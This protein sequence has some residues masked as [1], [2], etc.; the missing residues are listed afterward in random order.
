VEEAVD[1]VSEEGLVGGGEALG[2][3]LGE[4]RGADCV[5]GQAQGEADGSVTGL[6]PGGDLLEELLGA[7]DVGVEVAVDA[8]EGTSADGG[9]VRDGVEE[10][11]AARADRASERR[12]AGFCLETQLTITSIVQHSGILRDNTTKIV[13]SIDA[14]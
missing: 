4:E 14:K 5:G 8:D 9:P 3:V 11:E 7:L 12:D 6:E 2:D 13:R 10:T 1:D